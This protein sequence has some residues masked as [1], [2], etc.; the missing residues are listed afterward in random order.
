V[1]NYRYRSIFILFI[2]VQVIKMAYAVNDS[3]T[4]LSDVELEEYDSSVGREELPNVSR[5]SQIQPYQFE[6]NIIHT[7]ANSTPA[8]VP[9]ERRSGN[10]GWCRCGHCMAMETEMESICCK[11]EVPGEFFDEDC[12]TLNNNFISV[13]LHREVLKATLGGLNNLRGDRMDVTNRSLRYAGYRLFTWWVHNRLGQ[14]VRKAI[15]SCAV[16]AVRDSFPEGNGTY[17][18]FQEAVDEILS[19]L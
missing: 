6:P 5:E 10:V 2:R 9:I 16:W 19:L 15:P 18:P 7:S 8:E 11:D 12:I 4:D 3:G 13:C 1:L 14:G 17:I